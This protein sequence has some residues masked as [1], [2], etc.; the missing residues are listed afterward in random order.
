M[1]KGTWYTCTANA[2]F[3]ATEA[4]AACCSTAISEAVNPT[5]ETARIDDLASCLGERGQYIDTCVLQGV[6]VKTSVSDQISAAS[7]PR[8]KLS[9]M[10]LVTIGLGF[11]GAVS[12]VPVGTGVECTSFV[13]APERDWESSHGTKWTDVSPS[14]PC[15][16]LSPCPVSPDTGAEWRS[17]FSSPNDITIGA[18]ITALVK[19]VGKP[20][21]GAARMAQVSAQFFVAPGHTGVIR[22]WADA[23]LVPGTFTNCSDGKQYGGSGLLVNP[24][25][26]GVNLVMKP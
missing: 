23:M 10:V 6:S 26:V 11:L 13:P 25:R 21:V 3:G 2:T 12:A 20:Y 16:S 15:N 18:D 17:A 24:T 19:S 22:A 5:C 9:L 7:A 4:L 8:P 14:V 1:G